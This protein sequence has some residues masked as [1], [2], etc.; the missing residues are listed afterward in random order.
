MNG[1]CRMIISGLNNM[2]IT[3]VINYVHDSMIL[4]KRWKDT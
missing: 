3:E 1:Y 4:G 2:K